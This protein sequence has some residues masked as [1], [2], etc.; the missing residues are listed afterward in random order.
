MIRDTEVFFHHRVHSDDRRHRG[1]YHREQREIFFTT[2]NTEMTGDTERWRFVAKLF[3]VNSLENF[4]QSTQN[5]KRYF[6][7]RCIN[8]FTNQY[9]YSLKTSLMKKITVLASAVFAA[10]IFMN[11]NPGRKATAS[12]PLSYTYEGNLKEVISQNCSP[13][14]IPSKGGNKRAYDN[15][16]NVSNDIDEIIRRIS[17]NPG[18]RG[19]MP[20]K[21]PKLPDSTIAIFQKWKDDGKLEK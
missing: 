3:K 1:F 7:K 19:F 15:F 5:L 12:A 2:G 8:F 16:A 11:C 13:C 21:H 9:I 14:H 4:F 10:L 18:D 17:L 6:Y 20:M